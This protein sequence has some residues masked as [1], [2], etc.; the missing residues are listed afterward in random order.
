[1][2][3]A[4][5][6]DVTPLDIE[7]EAKQAAEPPWRKLVMA[8]GPEM[9]TTPPPNRQ[10]LL[11]DLRRDREGVFPTGKVGLLVAEGGAGKTMALVQLAMAVA[12]GG[13]WLGTFASRQGKVLL[14]LGEED[15]EEV[16][17]RVYRAAQLDGQ[18]MPPDG[19]IN[20]LPLAG[21]HCPL[22]GGDADSAFSTWLQKY[23]HA[24]GP[25]ALVI[26][27][28]LSRFAGQDAEKDNAQATRFL[29]AAESLITP[30]GGSSILIAHHSP[31]ADRHGGGAP[32]ARG[33]TAITDGAR[34]VSTLSAERIGDAEEKVLTLS[35]S[36]SNYAMC[37]PPL[38]LRY[39]E[40]GTLVPMA[41][42]DKQALDERK[43]AD[44]PKA[45]RNRERHIAVQRS[46]FEIIVKSPGIG[47]SDL[48]A[49]IRGVTGCRQPDASAA[50]GALI[51]STK[52]KK[53]K[54][55][56]TMG[57]F[58]VEGAEPPALPPA[59]VSS[60]DIAGDIADALAHV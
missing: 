29:Q 60:E 46:A 17:R 37:P 53:I 23:L 41:D 32:S 28:P 12:S 52:V 35:V 3:S 2:T 34:W 6:N 55:G 21:T 20:V 1:M 58:I 11:T 16:H 33:V 15:A 44:S 56:K 4:T 51:A 18:S 54:D 36:K 59:G 31:K 5:A 8:V 24:T 26:I 45:K 47:S 49:Q 50:V 7:G 42:A 27:D 25:Y 39:G 40:G 22:T 43:E 14:L 38:T 13:T 57:H 30:S 9:Y 19:M 48:L 10:W